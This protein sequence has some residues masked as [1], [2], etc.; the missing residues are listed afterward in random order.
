MLYTLD[1]AQSLLE[2][3]FSS[4]EDVAKGVLQ[5]IEAWQINNGSPPIR[6]HFR[7]SMKN[8]T[9]VGGVQILDGM[10]IG[11]IK[12]LVLEHLERQKN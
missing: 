5:A 11:E 8:L 10:E 2:R 6:E 12:D 4:N 1:I 9:R 7:E 3:A